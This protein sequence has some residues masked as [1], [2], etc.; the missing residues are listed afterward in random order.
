MMV[1]LFHADLGFSGGYVGVDVFFVI[2]GFLITGL[3]LKEQKE[4]RFSLSRFWVRRVRRILPASMVLALVTLLAGAWLM[5]PSDYEGV[6]K[7]AVAQQMMLSNV[8]FWRDTDYFGG[9]AETK[10]LLHTWSLAV[11][12]QFY[13]FYP[14]LLVGLRRAKPRT[15]ACLLAAL[16][17]ASFTLGEVMLT[18]KPRATFFLLPT[19]A[20][21][22]LIGCLLVFAPPPAGGKRLSELGVLGGLAVI[23][24]TGLMYRSSTPFPGVAALAPCFGAAAVIYYGTNHRGALTRLLGSRPLVTVGLM[25]YSLYLW[26]WPVLAY[27]RYMRDGRLPAGLAVAAL[28]LSLLLAFLS[29]RFVETPFRRPREKDEQAWRPLATAAIA[30]A[31]L[32]ATGAAVSRTGGLPA[33]LDPSIAELDRQR[34]D[35]PGEVDATG[36]PAPKLP[37]FSSSPEGPI[38]F[39]LWGDSHAMMVNPLCREL[40]DELGLRGVAAERFRAAPTL[41]VWRPAAGPRMRAW[42]NEVIEYIESASIPAVILVAAWNS[43]VSGA[44]TDLIVDDRSVGISPEGARKAL[45]DSLNKTVTRLTDAGVSVWAMEQ[46][47]EQSCRVLKRFGLAKMHGLPLPEPATEAWSRKRGSVIRGIFDSATE[48][49]LQPVDPSAAFYQDGI[50]R[51]HDPDGVFFKDSNHLTDHG[52]RTLLAGPLRE[53]LTA[54]KNQRDH[55]LPPDP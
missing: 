35:Q 3:I 19:R 44:P 26:H 39:I 55:S 41:D 33:R 43:K 22:L 47:P 14:L 52:V 46:A 15:Q 20:W 12:E 50:N 45:R 11:E 36:R 29:W 16:L 49:G 5:L 24:A 32:V 38:D 27:I 42:N 18:P 37:P 9:S 8:F 40:A 54:I 2:S 53:I 30:A 23:F 21:E 48:T 31:A 17:L 13:L 6:G 28:A 34:Q 1:L 51:T 10:P 25:S 7:S 4:G